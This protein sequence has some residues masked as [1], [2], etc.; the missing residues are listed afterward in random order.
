MER[1]KFIEHDRVRILYLD[2]SAFPNPRDADEHTEKA[3]QVVAREPQHSVLTITN[4][5]N[6]TFD[7]S[8]AQ[9][10]WKLASHNKPY[11]KAATVVGIDGVKATLL[12]LVQ[13]MA[14]RE[15]QICRTVDEA[16][17]WLSRRA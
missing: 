10:L 1:V 12:K 2:F 11:V 8:M 9:A 7:G 16:K 3:K 5:E 17:R 15:F 14:R 13:S 4:V 6:T